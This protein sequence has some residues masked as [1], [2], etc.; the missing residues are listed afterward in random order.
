LGIGI[1]GD[2]VYDEPGARQSRLEDLS[3]PVLIFDN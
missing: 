2:G 3:H 1:E